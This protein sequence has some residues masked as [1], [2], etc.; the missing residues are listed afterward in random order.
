MV[1]ALTLD[2]APII[3]IHGGSGGKGGER[4][5]AGGTGEGPRVH[6]YNN[7]HGHSCINALRCAKDAGPFASKACLPDTR[8]SLLS[9]IRRWALHPTSARTLLLHGAAGKGKSA[10]ANTI[11][12]QLQSDGL[13]VVPFFA[14]NRSVPDRSSSQLIPTWAKRLAQAHPRY[15]AYLTTL[16]SDPRGL[17]PQQLESSDI[18]EQ[19]EGLLIRGLSSGIDDGRLLI[20]T[21]DALDECPEGEATQLLQVLGELLSDPNLPPFV[22]F[23]FTYR[24]DLKILRTFEG[25]PTLEIPIDDEEGTAEDIR[26][27][28]HAQLNGHLEFKDMV[29]DVAKAAQTLFECAAA[30][31]RELTTRRPTSTSKRRQFLQRLQKGPVMSLYDTYDAILAMYFDE[32]EDPE[33]VRLFR[34]LMGWIFLV[35]TPQSRRVFRAFAVALVPEEEQDLIL[36]LDSLGSLL[37]G[38]A[39]EDDPI[40]P[41]HTSLR[42][43]LLDTTKSGAFSVDL[44]LD[45]QEELSLACLKIMNRELRFN[46]CGLSTLF[47]LNS[48]V[49][50]LPQKVSKCISPGLRY[51]CSATTHH[52]RGTLPSTSG[53]ITSPYTPPDVVVDEF[54]FFLQHQ[55]LFWLEAHSYM[56]TPRDG[57]GTMLPMFLEWT[58]GLNDEGLKETVLDYSKFEKRFR[59]GYMSS[60]PQIYISGLTFAPQKSIVSRCYRPRF[61]NLI[62]AAGALDRVWPPSET[63][64]IQGHSSAVLSVVFS[65]DGTRIASGSGD[66]TVRV[67]DTATGQQVGE[68]LA[69]HTGSV[70]SV[71]FSPDG[72]RIASGSDDRTVRVWDTATGQQVG[73]PLAGHTGRVQSVAFSPDGTRIASGSDDSTVRVWDTATGQQVGEPL[74]GHTGSVLA[75]LLNLVHD[76]RML[77]CWAIHFNTTDIFGY[78]E[79]RARLNTLQLEVDAKK[80]KAKPKKPKVGAETTKKKS[81]KKKDTP[82]SPFFGDQVSFDDGTFM[83]DAMISREVAAAA[84]QGAVGRVWEGL[85]VMVFTFGGSSHSKYMNYLLEMIVD[86]ELESNAFLRD[87][88]LMSMVLN[89]DGSEGGCKPCDI[90]QEFLNR[91][92]DPVV[93]RKD[94]DYGADHVR[95]T[96]SR[97]IKDIYDLKNDFRA[98]L[99]LSKRS[100]RHKKPHER[101][102][103]RTLLHEYQML[104]LHK[105]RPGRTLE[106]GRKVDNF[107]AGIQVLAGGALRKWAKRTTNSRIRQVLHGTSSSDSEDCESSDHESDWEDESDDEHVPM[108]PGSMYCKEGEVIINTVDDDDED[109]LAWPWGSTEGNE[110]EG[111]E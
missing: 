13:A 41:L 77:D 57:P 18:K 20:F 110:S 38:T 22:R 67:W 48:E 11:A 47:A 14:F 31:C 33:T 98:G 2:R 39:S 106:D 71:A 35:R 1:G 79:K 59:E 5:G 10:I 3:N 103:V 81:Q 54:R 70:L 55:F 16:Y 108:T 94:A 24:S 28:V 111:E 23:L 99:G 34:R 25:L 51:A 92:I 60:A 53:V 6:I 32:E 89:P 85:K 96:W 86:L 93:Q 69:G 95:N 7:V 73:E 26:K 107:E 66:S 100:G 88:N 91:C 45:S 9:R 46:I 42:D 36:I 72:T 90:F 52:M 78:F 50:E 58:L 76:M 82:K 84:A 75:Q 102:E 21:I 8:I 87:A 63:L 27:F 40:S 61:R 105:R 62:Q 30:L 29:D 19:G 104:E 109:I 49:K 43:F 4:G 44:G 80:T 65:P 101:P 64:V 74:A 37:S 17:G 68:P 15:L 12:G 83:H 97:N 56:Q